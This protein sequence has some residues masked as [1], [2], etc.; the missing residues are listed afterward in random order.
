MI[1]CTFSNIAETFV[2]GVIVGVVGVATVK[3]WWRK[4]KA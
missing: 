3:V 2:F 4:R 1:A